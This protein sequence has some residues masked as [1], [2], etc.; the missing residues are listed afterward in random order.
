MHTDRVCFGRALRD[1][2]N[3]SSAQ[4]LAFFHPG[5]H[6]HQEVAV[7]SPQAGPEKQRSPSSSGPPSSWQRER[8][9]L[10]LNTVI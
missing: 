10:P 7:G 1:L 8:E 4:K 6:E 5:L 2:Q 3:T 9:M